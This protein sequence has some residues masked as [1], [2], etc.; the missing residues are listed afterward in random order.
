MLAQSAQR[1]GDQSQT[2]RHREYD[3]K[4][5]AI[6]HE[7]CVLFRG[8]DVIWHE[9]QSLPSRVVDREQNGLTALVVAEQRES[10]QKHCEGQEDPFYRRI[11]RLQPKPEVNPEAAMDPNDE[12]KDSLQHPRGRRAHPK[13]EE[14]FSIALLRSEH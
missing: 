1:A 13:F 2:K 7:R 5:G 8:A 14:F 4:P 3:E 6:A 10:R 12:Q 11:K 9:V